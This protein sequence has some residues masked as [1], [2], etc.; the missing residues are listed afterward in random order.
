M[1]IIDE[2]DRPYRCMTMEPSEVERVVEFFGNFYLASGK[3]N[4]N[5]EHILV[6]GITRPNMTELSGQSFDLH[7]NIHPQELL[8]YFGYSY[9]DVLKLAAVVEPPIEG[10]EIIENMQKWYNGN[11]V[12]I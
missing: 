3:S 8:K 4:K 11:F 7:I 2:Y 5:V 9:D 10:G 12:S 1:L 6:A